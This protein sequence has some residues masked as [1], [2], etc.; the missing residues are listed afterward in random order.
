MT[1]LA[2]MILNILFY[3]HG[4]RISKHNPD[5]LF[6]IM[7]TEILA[8]TQIFCSNVDRI[9]NDGP[10]FAVQL[11]SP[12]FNLVICE[13]GTVCTAMCLNIL[14]T[15]CDHENQVKM[16]SQQDWIE[17]EATMVKKSI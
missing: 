6:T 16:H 7:I 17:S 2:S 9:G 14:N 8:L 13:K 11:L 1:G 15:I 4:D 10:D 12:A 3:N 5:F